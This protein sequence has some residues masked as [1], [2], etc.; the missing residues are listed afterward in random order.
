MKDGRLEIVA[1]PERAAIIERENNVALLGHHLVPQKSFV[2]P[3]VQN[4]LHAGA[5]VHLDQ[6]RIFFDGSKFGGLIV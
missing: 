3:F 2:V 1:A 5:A 6:H 4:V